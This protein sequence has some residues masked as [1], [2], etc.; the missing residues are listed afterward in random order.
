MPL[1]AFGDQKTTFRNWFCPSTLGLGNQTPALGL[2]Q[3]GLSLQ[4]YF[5]FKIII[6]VSMQSNRFL[7]DIFIYT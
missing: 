1:D 7:H 3:A 5:F 6:L 2:L 4:P